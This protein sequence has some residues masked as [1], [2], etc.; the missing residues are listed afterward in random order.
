VAGGEAAGGG[1]AQERQ[2]S[3]ALLLRHEAAGVKSAPGG[4]SDREGISPRTIRSDGASP[5]IGTADSSERCT[6]AAARGTG[7]AQAPS[8]S[9]FQGT[10]PP[11]RRSR[12]DH[13]QV[14]GD[15]QVRHPVLLPGG[16]LGGSGSAPAR[17]RRGRTPARRPPE[18][19]GEGDRP[20]D[21]DPLALPAGELVGY[22]HPA[23]AG[24]PTRTSSR[25]A[26]SRSSAPLASP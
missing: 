3:A 18:L 12:A 15:E 14:V 24:I 10:S 25:S 20:G 5:S 1:L 13:P 17:K 22:F 6:G 8:P 11:P 26:R 21:P 4:G 19:R 7:P 2:T 9:P 16:P 23:S